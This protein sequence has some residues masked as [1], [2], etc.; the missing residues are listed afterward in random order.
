[1]NKKIN[2]VIKQK[3]IKNGE[4]LTSIESYNREIKMLREEIIDLMSN[5]DRLDKYIADGR[6]EL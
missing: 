2:E 4:F 6:K 1:M 5:N 3:D